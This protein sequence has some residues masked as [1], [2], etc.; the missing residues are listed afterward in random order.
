MAYKKG[1]KIETGIWRLADSKLYLAEVSYA[2]PSTGKR[3]RDRKTTHRR[4]LAREWRK[5]RAS[6]ALRRE[7]RREKN[8]RAVP[9][10]KFSTEYLDNWS[11][12]EK[13][14]SS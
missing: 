12:L 8:Q 1:T 14:P 3:I 6:D 7:I 5:T 10:S 2:D 4:D 9:F 13:R 11:K